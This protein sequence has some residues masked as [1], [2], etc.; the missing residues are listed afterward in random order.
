[1]TV[2]A[3]QAFLDEN[4]EKLTRGL[5]EDLQQDDV[6]YTKDPNVRPHI[7]FGSWEVDEV[8]DKMGKKLEQA[9]SQFGIFP[10]T[11]TPSL[12]PGME[13]GLFLEPVM[14][15]ELIEFQAAIHEKTGKFGE[16]FRDCDIP[17]QWEAHLTLG[18]GITEEQFPM[19]M[20]ILRER[21]FPLEVVIQYMGLVTFGPITY[22]QVCEL[23]TKQG[24]GQGQEAG[25]G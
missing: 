12:K 17:G 19:V 6:W 24:L 22:H 1:M 4:S 9:C 15:R 2:L 14:T 23:T 20:N 8:T 7:T 11:L 25:L 3:L 16:Y 21:T 10:L 18:G 5:W 13:A